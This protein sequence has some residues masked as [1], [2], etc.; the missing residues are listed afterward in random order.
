MQITY[1]NN[2]LR[3][4]LNSEKNIIKKY[5][6]DGRQII[7]VLQQLRVFENLSE[8][9]TSLPFRRHKLRGNL[10]S[11]F[12]VNLFKGMRLILKPLENCERLSEIKS[13]QIMDI[14]DYHK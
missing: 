3:K 1:Y 9:P 2:S 7:L 8:V 11:C 13:I 12:G 6:K 10:A 4:L 5:G 14:G